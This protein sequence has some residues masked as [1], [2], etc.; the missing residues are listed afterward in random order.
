[1]ASNRGQFYGRG[2][3]GRGKLSFVEMIRR[4]KAL[5]EENN[6]MME[7]DTNPTEMFAQG[8]QRGQSQYYYD[9]RGQGGCGR[10][11]GQP[12]QPCPMNQTIPRKSANSRLKRFSEPLTSDE[13]KESV[14][15]NNRRSAPVQITNPEE[16]PMDKR[17]DAGIDGCICLRDMMR[18][19][20]EACGHAY[21]GRLRKIC[22]IH[23]KDIYLYDVTNCVNCHR[24]HVE[25][26]KPR[27]LEF[28]L[29]YKSNKRNI[30]LPSMGR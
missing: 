2:S 7:I 19:F 26:R 18:I 17:P 29:N 21:E 14:N 10:R 5:I 24:P 22:P 13:I 12:G 6:N 1:M 4:D 8:S 16:P 11:G 25:G 20:C 27:L 3:R 28:H 23:P 30:L 9:S 15:R